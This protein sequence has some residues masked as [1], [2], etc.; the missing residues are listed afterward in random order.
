MKY[1]NI[2]LTAA[3]TLMFISSTVVAQSSR[4]LDIVI[5]DTNGAVVAGASLA[6]TGKTGAVH[7]AVTDAE[8]KAHLDGLP[9]GEYRVRVDAPG[10]PAVLREVTV[11]ASS[12]EAEITLQPG[13]IAET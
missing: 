3:V 6:V 5:K 8:G 9:E 1:L 4:T 10:F 2:L 7:N 11:T 13:N 12:K